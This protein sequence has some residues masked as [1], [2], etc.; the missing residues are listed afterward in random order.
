MKSY[1]RIYGP[2]IA[3]ALRV[4]EKIATESPEVMISSY[5]STII[6]TP[7]TPDYPE[8]MS[9]YYATMPD[10][11]PVKEKEKLISKS[12]HTLGEYDFFFEWARDPSW[13]EVEKL[14]TKIDEALAPLGCRY[15]MVTR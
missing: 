3:K 2:P 11:I 13:E 1:I 8:A 9:R 14:L 12:G 15:H 7:F 10:E 6:P 4:L 5:Y